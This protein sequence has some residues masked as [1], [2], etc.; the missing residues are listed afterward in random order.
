MKKTIK[1]STIRKIIRKELIREDNN[2][3][4]L[5]KKF[6]VAF[7]QLNIDVKGESSELIEIVKKMTHLLLIAVDPNLFQNMSKEGGKSTT[8]ISN[9]LSELINK[10]DKTKKAKVIESVRKLNT[11]ISQNKK[12][13]NKRQEN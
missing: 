10:L 7:N 5:D 3:G 6:D 1:E 11:A 2:Q 8:Q 12:P 9:E 13:A 4:R